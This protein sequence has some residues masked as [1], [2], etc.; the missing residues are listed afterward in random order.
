VAI[1]EDGNRLTGE[2][3]TT[4][5]EHAD[6]IQCECPTHLI[7]ILE[8]IREFKSYTHSCIEKFPADAKTHAWLYESAQNLDSL[9]S[10]TIAQLARFEGFID[11][12]N[13]FTARKPK[14]N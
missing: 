12:Q 6:M 1:F 5:R 11:D 8:K 10:G 3:L 4:L 13:Q 2:A 14:D 7:D 9:L